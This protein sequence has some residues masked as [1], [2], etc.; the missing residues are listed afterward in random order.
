MTFMDGIIDAVP[1]IS[2]I[3]QIELLCWKSNDFVEQQV[4]DSIDDSIVFEINTMVI[5]HC[6][7]LRRERSIKT[8]DAIIAGTALCYGYSLVTRNE[9]DFRNI[10]GLK[11]LNP[12][13]IS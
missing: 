6:V 11:L 1:N 4:R 7:K 8:P 12:H 3:V 2:V 13:A 10:H 5:Q 9:K